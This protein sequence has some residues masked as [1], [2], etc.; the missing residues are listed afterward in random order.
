MSVCCYLQLCWPFNTLI[1]TG[2]KYGLDFQAED[3]VIDSLGWNVVNDT[4]TLF[5][6]SSFESAFPAVILVCFLPVLN[7]DVHV[8]TQGSSHMFS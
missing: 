5:T 3:I 7:Q 6:T 2:S 8:Q 1:Q 4:L